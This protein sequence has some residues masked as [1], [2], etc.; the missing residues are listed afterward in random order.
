MPQQVPSYLGPALF[1]P[2][3]PVP[4]VPPAP[5]V[6]PV[7]P[8]PPAPR[9]FTPTNDCG[10]LHCHD[11]YVHQLHVEKERQEKVNQGQAVITI[12]VLVVTQV[13]I[14]LYQEQRSVKDSTFVQATT[15]VNTT[16]S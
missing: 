10:E 6:P 4:T 9:T 12:S 3:A 13:D 2:Q 15:S 1:F 8:V 14:Y 7:P 5:P 16:P 11:C